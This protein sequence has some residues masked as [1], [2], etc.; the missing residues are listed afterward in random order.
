M[1]GKEKVAA[2]E[3]R[4][5]LAALANDIPALEGN[6]EEGTPEMEEEEQEDL[7]VHPRGS[8]HVSCDWGSHSTYGLPRM[9]G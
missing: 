8:P 6:D 5:R 3:E 1:P 7:S 9:G 2:R 4:R